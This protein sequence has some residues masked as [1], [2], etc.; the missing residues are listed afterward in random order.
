MRK[1]GNIEGKKA[2]FYIIAAIII[3]IILFGLFAVRNYILVGPKNVKFYDLSKELNLE[4][5]YVIDHGIYKDEELDVLVDQWASAYVDYSSKVTEVGEWIFVYG[6]EKKINATVFTNEI[7]GTVS[8]SIGGGYPSSIEITGDAK[9]YNIKDI[10][11][12]GKEVKL[13]AP[14]KNEYDFNLTRGENF[15]FVISKEEYVAIPNSPSPTGAVVAE[16]K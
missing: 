16:E 9:K 2:Q 15:F 4:S 3:S 14:D 1:R 6:N 13:V 12:Q 10:I 7:S 11:I 5:G 8:I